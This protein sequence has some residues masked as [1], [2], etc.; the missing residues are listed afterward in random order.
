MKRFFCLM[1]ALALAAALFGC[2]MP[3]PPENSNT[4][5]DGENVDFSQTDSD[6]FTNRDLS[7]EYQNAQAIALGDGDVT[8]TQ[9]G[10]YLLSGTLDDGR[11]TVDVSG[12]EDKVQLVLGGVRIYSEG[13]AAICVLNADKVFITLAAGTEN[14]LETG[15]S[16]ETLDGYEMNA[17]IYSRSDLT[18]NGSGSLHITASAG[19]GI[20]CK[21]DLAITGGT[22]QITCANQ[23]LDANDSVRICGGNISVASGKDGIHGENSEDAS[24]G[25]VYISG[26]KLDLQSAGDGISAGAYLQIKNADI[27]V[28]AGG[29]WE[30]S[31]KDHSDGWGNMGGHMG[32]RP[33]SG[34]AN[35]TVTTEAQSMKGLKAAGSILIGSGTF[36]LDCA[37]D[38]IHSNESI[39]VSGGS[40]TLSTGDDGIHAEDTLT[41]TDCDMKIN[42]AYEGLEAANIDIRGGTVWMDCTDDGLNAAGGTDQSG[43]TGGRDGM[44]GPG[45]GGGMGGGYG[46]IEISGGSLTVYAGGD[47]LDSNGD[48]TISGGTTLVYNP[49]SG[50]TSILDSQNQP[51]VTGGTYIGLGITTAMAE[52][53][54]AQNSTQGFI[55][56]SCG[57]G[58]GQEISF[59]DKNGN[60][61]LAVTTEYTTQLMI[62][63]CPDMVKGESYTITVGDQSQSFT[64]N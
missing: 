37:D 44:F 46:N 47:G 54:S 52:V 48:L 53:F 50:D 57:L 64:A 39:T 7:G 32:G 12:E 4:P 13:G 61:F 42:E 5:S 21:D 59:S 15:A 24:L 55:A 31:T 19:H 62:V 58:A 2:E 1:T 51:I 18:V 20:S 49:K 34:I 43:T 60:E 26:G 17:A 36:T 33:R 9:P 10:T 29:G 3:D 41:V 38:A 14:S 40:F 56:V 16:T 30:N 8:I 22:M 45:M 11:V 25:F 28:L 27:T 6:M 35:E 63:S 23:G